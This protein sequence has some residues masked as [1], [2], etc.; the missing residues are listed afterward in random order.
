MVSFTSMRKQ[1]SDVLKITSLPIL[2]AS[3]CCLTPVV[4]VLLGL[5]T[6]GFAAAF[7]GVLEGKYKPVFLGGGLLLLAVSLIVYFRS[8]GICTLDQAKRYRNE[9]INKVLLVLVFAVIGYVLFFNIFLG[10][11]GT[12]LGLWHGISFAP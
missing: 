7:G 12:W 1:L 6:I 2:F 4:L 9:I 3:L 11:V 5:S 10:I 8:L